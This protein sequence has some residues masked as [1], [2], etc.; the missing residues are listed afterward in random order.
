M[1]P[2]RQAEVRR[3]SGKPEPAY[4]WKAGESVSEGLQRIV[5]EELGLAIWQ[6]SKNS[7]HLDESVHEARKSLKKTRSALRLMQGCLGPEYDQESAALR[8]AGLQLS[9]LRDAQALIEIFDELDETY[10]KK[11]G[12][13]NL[14]PVRDGLLAG[15]Q[16]L[17]RAFR[18]EHAAAKVVAGLSEVVAHVEKWR[19]KSCDH[20]VLS[21]G[22]AKTIRQN[23]KAR[24]AAYASPNAENFHEWRKRCKDLRYHLSLIS[25]AWPPVLEGYEAAAKELENRLGDDHNLAV[26]HDTILAHAQDFG[27]EADTRALLK[28]AKQ[29]ETQLRSEA[30]FLAT[31]L[32]TDSPE[33][34]RKRL[35]SCWHAW[36]SGHNQR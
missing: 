12:Q 29:H 9:P 2:E 4:H 17:S 30:K 8:D 33:Q 5:C 32:Y 28:I 10:R 15:K 22:F 14:T 27:K 23:R 16:A 34:W 20:R 3:P 13:L 1:A 19:P 26:L 24:D 36:K 21:A 6:L 11:L 25:K 35:D 18:Q 7:A 31:R